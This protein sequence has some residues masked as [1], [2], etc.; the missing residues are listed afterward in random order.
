MGKRVISAYTPSNTDPETR[1]RIFVQRHKLLARSVRWCQ[2]SMLTGNKHH[3]LF[4][5]PRGSGKTHL[6]SMI[7]DSLVENPALRDRMRIAWLGEDSTFTGL[8]DVA[9]EIADELAQE[10]PE[11]FEFDYRGHAASL[12][13]DEAAESILTS[14]M[15]R[16]GDRSMLVIIE[17]LDRAFLGLGDAGQK[18]WRAFLQETGRVA[19]LASS[20]QLFEDI[21]TR[22]A[23]FF[24]FFEIIHLEPLSVEDARRLMINIARESDQDQSQ[25]IEFLKTSE[26]RYRVRALWH[27]AGGNHRMYVMLSEFISKES[28]DGLVEAFEA[29]ADE[30]TPYYQERVRSLSPQQ[31]RIVQSLCNASGAMTVKEV[32]ANTFIAERNVSKQLGELRQKG[33]VKSEKRGKE[34]YYEMS[35]PLMR[36]CLEVKK[37]RGKPLKLVAE[38]LR[39]WFSAGSIHAELDSENGV[40]KSARLRAYQQ[41]ALQTRDSFQAA[42]HQRMERE[43]ESML[44]GKNY[45]HAMDL[46]DELAFAL[47]A[48]GLRQKSRVLREQG[49]LDESLCVINKV[50]SSPELTPEQE[51]EALLTR[52]GTYVRLG[53][54]ALAIADLN[55]VIELPDAPVGLKAEAKLLRG[56]SRSIGLDAAGAIADYT[57]V[58]ELPD[59][60]AV[61]KAKA[62][63]NRAISYG[64]IGDT[65]RATGDCTAVIE[66]PDAP[67]ELKARALIHRGACYHQIGD[68]T[69]AMGDYTA[70]IELA[71]TP[72]DQKA[73][74]LGNRGATHWNSGE[75]DLALK[76]FLAASETDGVS[77]E[78]RTWALF[79]IPEAMI[80]V[81]SISES[82]AA[83]QRAF[84]EGD[85]A[86]EEYGGSSRDIIRMILRGAHESWAEYVERI[87]PIYAQ[88]RALNSL[89]SGLAESISDLDAGGFSDEQLAQWNRAWQESGGPHDE[90][91]IPLAALDASIR[92]ISTKSDRPLFDLPLEIRTIVRPLLKITLG[93]T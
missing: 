8:I 18:R 2:E 23:P 42:L 73:M 52:C 41:L 60:P 80:P 50:L 29:L 93:D 17:N 25:L 74:A 7:H 21:S 27:L 56:Y 71:D 70:V 83:I 61:E 12:D 44:Q 10:N 82:I 22:D 58:I 3:L 77:S 19:T 84:A 91:S 49:Q 87:V 86:T 40:P 33:Y 68:T 37:Q 59:A 5:G 34:S 46:A 57:A 63:L 24:G 62:L 4:I 69:R 45:S 11:E 32:A 67:A 92:A 89:G 53:D 48:S 81:R 76:D 31:A 20:Q 1:R 6:V 13:G 72:A 65:T 54:M 47:P 39:A 30:L 90:L 35:E 75:Y 66:M 9:L 36:L 16:L 55:T 15:E 43:F 14:V 26:G 64:Q 38:F 79:C 88:Y 51:A 78:E 28:L 85:P